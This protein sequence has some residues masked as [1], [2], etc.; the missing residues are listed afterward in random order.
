[1]GEYVDMKIVVRNILK[2]LLARFN[3][4]VSILEDRL[5][6]TNLSV[7][8]LHGIITEYEMRIK[9]EDGTSH[10]ETTFFTSKKTSKDKQTQKSKTCR[11]KDE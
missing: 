5:D 3:P 7:D 4:K 6:K 8:K 11:C 2:T 9:E 1:M 10:F